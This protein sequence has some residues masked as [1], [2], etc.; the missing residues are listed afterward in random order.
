MN[1]DTIPQS[2]HRDVTIGKHFSVINRYIFFDVLAFLRKGF[3]YF[4][5]NILYICRFGFPINIY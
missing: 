3:T 2:V 4:H 5:R 1:D